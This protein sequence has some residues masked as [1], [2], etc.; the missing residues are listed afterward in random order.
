M[1]HYLASKW[2]VT[3]KVLASALTHTPAP[4]YLLSQLEANLVIA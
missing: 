2:R 1:I 4:K 3:I